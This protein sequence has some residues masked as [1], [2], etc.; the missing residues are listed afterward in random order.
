MKFVSIL[1]ALLALGII[2]TIHEFGHFLLAKL[3]KVKV[4]EF[5]IFMG[6]KLFSWKRK[7]T[8]YS[9]RL[10]PLGGMCR[11]LG[12][13]GEVDDPGSYNNK[14]NWQK[15]SILFAGA[16]FNIL[17]G[18]LIISLLFTFNGYTTTDIRVPSENSIAYEAG[19]REGDKL[20]KVNGHGITH[21]MDS[22]LFTFIESKN[23][24]DLLVERDGKEIPINVT[25]EPSYKI[26]A[27]FQ[28]GNEQTITVVGFADKSIAKDAGLKENDI[29]RKVND[30]DVT[31]MEDISA[32]LDNCGGK[33]VVFGVERN[34]E[35]VDIELTPQLQDTIIDSVY[36]IGM[37]FNYEQ[38]NFFSASVAAS[39]YAVSIIKNTFYSFKWMVT[40]RVGLNELSGPVGIVKTVSDVVEQGENPYESL[41]NLLNMMAFI[42]LSI[43][44]FNLI[45]FPALDGFKMFYIFIEM[46]CR[47][48]F[49]PE[50]EARISAVGLFV[51]LAFML[52]ITFSDIFKFI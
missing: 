10:L 18:L 7:E 8:E 42:S 19:I 20:L 31:S 52:I 50:I 3:N 2:V 35:I 14:K 36:T 13:E 1:L 45:P 39:K 26:G 29:V 49:K 46:I 30:K 34:G 21:P 25:T 6:P 15:L 37:T 24:I 32:E 28:T 51:L 40:G 48:K 17:T 16:F 47:K 43:G 9:F 41:I 38:G 12:E 27:V 44:I 4:L 22:S 11:M 5:W 33:S 23:S